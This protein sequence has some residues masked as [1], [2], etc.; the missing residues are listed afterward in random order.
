MEKEREGVRRNDSRD[1]DACKHCRISARPVH[2]RKALCT[3]GGNIITQHEY[4]SMSPLDN[5]LY[6]NDLRKEV[7]PHMVQN[8]RQKHLSNK[9]ANWTNYPYSICIWLD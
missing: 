1:K 6:Q 9:R 8:L 2:Q 4:K 7:F 3:V 5:Q